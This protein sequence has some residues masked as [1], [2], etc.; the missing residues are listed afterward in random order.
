MKIELPLLVLVVH[1]TQSVF[2]LE[3]Y[4][5]N[6]SYTVGIANV[7]EGVIITRVEGQQYHGDNMDCSWAV[8]AP[9]NHRLKVTVTKVDLDW[10]P[11]YASC[12]GYD[13]MR[14]VEGTQSDG[15]FVTN[16]CSAFNPFVFLSKGSSLHFRF[17]TTRRNYYKKEGVE[18]KFEAF[19][20]T[21]CPPDWFSSPH[22]NSDCLLLQQKG[23]AD[24]A[25]AHDICKLNSAN[26]AVIKSQTELDAIVAAASAVNLTRS[27]W[28]GMKDLSGS[29]SFAWID[30]SNSFSREVFEGTPEKL[31][32]AQDFTTKK[33]VARECS[34]LLPFVCKGAKD[35]STVIINEVTQAPPKEVPGSN[36]MVLTIILAILA[37]LVVLIVFVVLV[38][39][40]RK[41]GNCN[42]GNK[43]PNRE[44][45]AP[46]L[47]D[48]SSS[49]GSPAGRNQR[50]ADTSKNIMLTSNQHVAP[51]T[52]NE[53]L[54]HE[55]L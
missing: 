14:V 7:H 30:G 26:L 36:K 29:G 39:C 17:T 55:R 44:T 9:R 3:T 28:I 52:Y 5:C 13:F 1:A 43:K 18:L 27:A 16:I 31:C 21:F 11:S 41:N 49:S 6:N 10:S 42:C 33:W 51:P 8:V 53:A 12:A 45:S 23:Q 15:N 34:D 22:N 38:W 46:G 54:F 47:S 32:A 37:G 48:I 19:N 40:F 35:G 20:D 25:R 2:S 50:S 4:Y 24:W